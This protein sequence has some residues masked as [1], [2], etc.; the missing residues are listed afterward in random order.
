ME[1]LA[2]R[3]PW[4]SSRTSCLKSVCEKYQT[5][6]LW[7]L[8]AQSHDKLKSEIS[9]ALCTTPS[10]D[11]P[12]PFLLVANLPRNLWSLS[13]FILSVPSQKTLTPSIL[14]H[15]LKLA[16]I[17]LFLSLSPDTLKLCQVPSDCLQCWCS[18]GHSRKFCVLSSNTSRLK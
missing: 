3:D 10:R 4:N 18:L 2:G 17:R 9:T 15:F 8:A 7:N 12:S 14:W 16:A 6:G 5:G 1:V 13:F 11:A